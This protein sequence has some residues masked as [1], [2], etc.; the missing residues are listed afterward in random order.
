MPVIASEKRLPVVAPQHKEVETLL[1]KKTEILLTKFPL[2]SSKSVSTRSDAP[3]ALRLTRQQSHGSSSS[4]TESTTTT[5]VSEAVA[6]PQLPTKQT[7]VSEAKSR[8]LS[9][10][11]VV[12]K[13]AEKTT[14]IP[15]RNDKRDK[16]R[17]KTTGKRFLHVLC[18]M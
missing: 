11:Q 12:V 16:K 7:I 4:G 10:A 15:V 9:P 17:K 8:S 3:P 5:A 14:A 18:F 2:C 13:S 1:W 6:P